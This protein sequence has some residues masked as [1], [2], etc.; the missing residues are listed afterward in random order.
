MR[1]S[2]FGSLETIFKVEVGHQRRFGESTSLTTRGLPPRRPFVCHMFHFA[3][4]FV[5]VHHPAVNQSHP[6]Q[7]EY[8]DL[9][10]YLVRYNRGMNTV[11][12]QNCCIL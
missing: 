1:S 2:A 12:A 7:R 10:R 9:F 8:D 6:L 3:A 5:G 4:L 11:C